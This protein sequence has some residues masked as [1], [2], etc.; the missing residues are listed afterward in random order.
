MGEL[1]KVLFGVDSSTSHH[2]EETNAGLDRPLYL[3]NK[4]YDKTLKSQNYYNVLRFSGPNEPC[5]RWGSRY[6]HVVVLGHAQ[7]CLQFI[8]STL[9]S[10]EQQ[11]CN[12]CYQSSC[13][14]LLYLLLIAFGC[15]SVSCT[16]QKENNCVNLLCNWHR[17]PHCRCMSIVCG[18]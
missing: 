4:L 14:K 10:R 11:R 5:I 13:S 16:I 8:F 2:I 18:R 15:G 9:F 1:I 12:L 6:P 3:R 7:T 17:P